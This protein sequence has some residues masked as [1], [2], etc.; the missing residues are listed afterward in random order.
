MAMTS[1]GKT[2]PINIEFCLLI[3]I[4]GKVS[5]GMKYYNYLTTFYIFCLM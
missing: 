4:W 3:K 5:F 1:S 2:D